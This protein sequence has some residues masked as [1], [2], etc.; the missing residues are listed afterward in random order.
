MSRSTRSV[1]QFGPLLREY[2]ESHGW[3]QMT[4]AAQIKARHQCTSEKLHHTTLSRLEAGQ[5]SPS[6]EMVTVLADALGLEDV[7]RFR[8]YASAGFLET[9]PPEDVMERIIDEMEMW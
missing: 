7:E 4:M 9:I 1:P 2:R 6:L 5:R 8:F 3:S